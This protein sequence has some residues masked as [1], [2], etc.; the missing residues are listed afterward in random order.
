MKLACI[1]AS[2]SGSAYRAM[3][4]S[5]GSG[6]A[7]TSVTSEISRTG[8]SS[9]RLAM[10]SARIRRATASHAAPMVSAGRVSGRSLASSIVTTASYVTG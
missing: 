4:S 5:A 6:R 2:R 10:P 7:T 1:Q 9:Y 8:C 3:I